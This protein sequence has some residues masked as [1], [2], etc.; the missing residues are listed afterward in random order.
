V[1][2]CLALAGCGTLG[3][4]NQLLV[5]NE[6]QDFDW[7]EKGYVYGLKEKGICMTE[8]YHK[9]VEDLKVNPL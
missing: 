9:Q 4:S 8:S 7:A 5:V 3:K 6:G 2:I 1:L